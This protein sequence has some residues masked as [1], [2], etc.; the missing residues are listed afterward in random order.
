MGS[1]NQRT[2][3]TARFGFDDLF[4][5]ALEAQLIFDFD[6]TI[7]AQ[8]ARHEAMT[9]VTRDV[10][11]GRFMFDSWPKNPAQDGPDT[12]EIIRRSIERMR[13]TGEPDRVPVQRHDIRSPE[14]GF[15]SHF[16]QIIHSPLRRDGEIVAV[17]QTSQ[18][19]TADIREKELLKAQRHTALVAAGLTFFEY[20]PETD[21]FDRASSVDA[22]F[23]FAPNEAGPL[24]KPF[25]D[26]I[27]PDDLPVVQQTVEDVM[28]GRT[29]TATFD[30]RVIIPGETQL[31]YVRAIGEAAVGPR[32][33]KSKLVGVFT[34]RTE[35]VRLQQDLQEAL[36]AKGAMLSEMNHR[37]RNSLSLAASVLRVQSTGQEPFVVE[38]L[39]KARQRITAIAAV[40][41]RLYQDGSLK[42]IRLDRFL[43]DLLDDQC[44]SFD[45]DSRPIEIVK[46]IEEISLQ[47]ERAIPLGMIFGELIT[48]AFKYGLPEDAKSKL[49]VSLTCTGGEG[50]LEVTNTGSR[51]TAEHQMPSSGFGAGI[52]EAFAKQLGGKISAQRSEEGDTFV[53][54]VSFP[55]SA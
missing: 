34:D 5:A 8:N 23:G 14:G 22:M 33:G 47:T 49:T 41:G 32:D 30:Y 55:V 7:L 54:K 12:E 18:D 21:Y 19:V 42:T 38:S 27:H 13:E 40:H 3:V 11:V 35:D 26:R 4:D 39:E 25:F 1:S 48:N 50:C 9:G 44:S 31:R 52:V 2:E 36:D 29:E 53:A 24:A 15:E 20:F 10:C 51:K 17:L 45:C 37:I 6:L 28:E 46:D 43:T 16:W